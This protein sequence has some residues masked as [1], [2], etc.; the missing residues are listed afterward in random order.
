ML[1]SL[2]MT[3]L[4]NYPAYLYNRKLSIP[5]I[6]ERYIMLDWIAG[7]PSYDLCLDQLIHDDITVKI[8]DQHVAIKDII[9]YMRQNN[10][11]G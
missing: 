2:I 6:C 10:Q 7:L 1:Q 3:V 4:L 5:L 9:N 8:Q 11:F